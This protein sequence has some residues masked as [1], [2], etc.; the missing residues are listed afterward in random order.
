MKL[1]S[2]P[3]QGIADR[4]CGLFADLP[5]FDIERPPSIED[6]TALI[7]RVKLTPEDCMVLLNVI[8]STLVEPCKGTDLYALN[9]DP[10][11]A[12][13]GLIDA[14]ADEISN[15]QGVTV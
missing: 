12:A 7:R 3:G 8:A 10:R 4:A 13:S 2:L 14:A 9:R 15:L 1:S 6:V 11:M 5:T